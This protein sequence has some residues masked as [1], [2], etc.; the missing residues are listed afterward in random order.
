MNGFDWRIGKKA[1]SSLTGV[2]SNSTSGI[3]CIRSHFHSSGSDVTHLLVRGLAHHT[4]TRPPLRRSHSLSLF[5][6]TS[7]SVIYGNC[8]GICLVRGVGCVSG[9]GI[10]IP[11][12]NSL[13]ACLGV[14]AM[15]SVGVSCAHLLPRV[16]EAPEH[17]ST[18]NTGAPKARQATFSDGM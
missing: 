4:F 3:P 8:C 10:L 7:E 9:K 17:A 18:G 2:L 11:V 15:M 1:L 5:F 14:Q 13:L 12:L 16:S 6:Q